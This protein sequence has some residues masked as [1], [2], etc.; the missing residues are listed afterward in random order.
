[1]EKQYFYN[2]IDSFKKKML[3]AKNENSWL[4]VV[5]KIGISTLFFL[6]FIS[7]LFTNTFPS[8]YA[9]TL[10]HLDP[11]QVPINIFP[12]EVI[13]EGWN[14]L[15]AVT[16]QDLKEYSLFQ[17]FNEINSVFINSKSIK[18]DVFTED[19]VVNGIPNFLN[20]EQK[21][22]SDVV[23]G[24]FIASTT[25]QDSE[26]FE[27]IEG[28]SV[29]QTD[30]LNKNSGE[31]LDID[32]VNIVY[33]VEPITEIK[34]ESDPVFESKP[35]FEIVPKSE[36]EQEIQSQS[37]H[38]IVDDQ[39]AA[40]GFPSNYLVFNKVAK[41]YR[42]AVAE[43]IEI[44]S[45]STDTI[46][47]LET[48]EQEELIKEQ[49]FDKSEF[50][51]DETESLFVENLEQKTTE[52]EDIIASST[53]LEEI[54][55]TDEE[56]SLPLDNT[57]NSESGDLIAGKKEVLNQVPN[58]IS[59][60][61]FD[62]PNLVSG[63][64][65][66]NLQLRLSLAGQYDLI[67]GE[68]IPS[69]EVSY[70]FDTFSKESG[71]IIIDGEISNAI[72]GGYYLIS[73]PSISDP[74]L[75]S[76][77]TI[78]ISFI[79]DIE[80]LN[81][82]YVDSAWLEMNTVIYDK[83]LLALRSN[84]DEM[85]KHLKSPMIMKFM[86]DEIDFT[87]T[88]LPR[89]NL[90]YES[91]RNFLVQT[92]RSFIGKDLATIDKIS[93]KHN[94][95]QEI[96]V[97][98]KVSITSDGLISI[99]LDDEDKQ[100]LPPG[101]YTVEVSVD[102]GGVITT[103]TFEFQWG[104]LS[105]NT[106]QTE[107]GNGE[108]VKIS[109]A[110]LASNGSTICDARLNLYITDP[111]G[112]ISSVPVLRS[113]KCEGDNVV[114]V[115]DYSSLITT[116]EFG[117]YEIYLER[118]NNSG[119]VL[120]HVTETFYVVP[121]QDIVI[122][123]NGPTRIF[124]P[125][126]YRVDLSVHAL[127][128]SFD[129]KLVE[130]VPA[131]FV[132]SD[133]NAEIIKNNNYTELV[134]DM[135]MLNGVT[136][137]VSYEFNAPD[138]SPFLFNLGPAKLITTEEIEIVTEVATE[139]NNIQSISTEISIP[140]STE[141]VHVP[142]TVGA[143][144]FVTS[145][146][147][148]EIVLFEEHRQWQIASDALQPNIPSLSETPS[149]DNLLSTT[150][151]PTIGGFATI[152]PD[153]DVVE[154]EFQID[155]NYDFSSPATTTYSFNFP[156]DAGW[157]AATFASGA[158]T[159]YTIQPADA[160]TDGV[161]YW[162]RVR[163]KDPTDTDT[164]TSYSQ[165]R[166]ITIDTSLSRKEWHQTLGY[167]FERDSLVSIA[168]T[169]GAAGLATGLGPVPTIESFT[170]NTALTTGASITLTKPSGVEV[171][172]LLLI[173]VGNDDNTATAQWDNATLKPSGFTLINEAGNATA[174]A[175]TAAFYRIADGTEG[176]TINVPS[177]ANADYWGYYV[178][179]SGVDQV[180]P[181]NVTG[182]DYM[183]GNNTNHSVTSVTTVTDNSLAFYLLAG[184]GGDTFPF[185]VS[186]TGWSESSEIQAGT[187]FGNAA[188][189]WGTRDMTT[190]GATGNATVGMSVS[191]GASGFQFAL[192]PA[193]I[194]S[195]T[196]M[197]SEVDFDWVSNED[198]WGDISWNVTEPAGTDTF[199]SVYYS[200]A[201]TCD[202]LVSDVDLPGNS[203]GFDATS[204]GMVISSLSTSTYNRICLEMTLD[205]GTGTTSPTLNDWSINWDLPNQV[206]NIPEYDVPPAFDNLL[207]TSTP[208][209]GGFVSTDFESDNMEY[210]FILD[211]D[212]DF[213]SPLLTKQSS[214]YPTDAGWS[215]ATFAS[216]ATTT[217]TIQPADALTDG[218]TY[219]WKV[220]ARDPSGSNEWS[221]Y[222][223]ARS[224]TIDISVL[225]LA[226]HQTL[227][228][229]F[230]DGVFDN[231]ATTTG[232][233]WLASTSSASSVP[234][235]ESFTS[236]T[237]LT[238]GASI[239]LTK[240]SGVEVG[241]LLLIMVGND[242]NT[243]T[244]QWDNATLKPS[245]FT[246]INEAGNATADA[247]T[248]AFYRIADGTEGATINVPSQANA[249]YWGYYVRV[250]GVDQV[251]PINVTGADYMSGNNTN[252]SVTSVTTV[253][254]NSLAFYLLAGDGGDTFPFTV[255][256]TG[257]SESSEIQAGTGFGNAAGAWG[258]R[259]MTTAGATGNATV[260]MSVSDGASG[261][262]FALTP[263][264]I[265]SGTIMSSE[266]DFDWVSNEDD[267]GDIS[268]NVTEP[269]GTD[270]FL[271]VYYSN[272][273]TCDTLVSDVDLPGNSVGFDATST[274]MVISSLST[275]TYNRI[276]LEMTLD[277][278][279]GTTS[280]TLN[281]WSI[282]WDLPNQVPNIP[283][284]DVPPA[285]DNLLATSTPILG[286]FVSTD[287]ESDNMEYE[288]I[289][290]NDFDF[291]S[292]LL[293]KQSSNYPTDA[294]WSAA[295]F[296]SGAT[297]TY[298]IQ[299]ADALTDGVT[300]WWKVRARDPSGSNEWSDY[301]EARSVTIDISV[302]ELA[303]HQTLGYQFEDGVF[304]N[305]ATTTGGVWLASTSS[306]SSVPTI[307]SFTSN[308]ALT[309]GASITLTKPSG[310]EV[311]DLLL[312]MVG[313]DDNTA[314]A[315]WDNATLKPSG[316]TLINEAGNATADAHTAA[317]Y[318]IAD[319]TE[320]ATIN[321]PSQANADYWGYYVRVSGVDQVTPINVTGA[322]YM[323]GNNTNHSVTSVTTVTD[324]SLAFYLLAGD[325]GDTFPF[326]V[327]GTGWS[328]SSEIQAGTGF[329][330]A[331]G[332]WGTRDM[333]TAGAT[334]NATVGMSVSDGAS[335]FQ[336]ALTPASG[337]VGSVISPEVDFDWVS[338]QTNWG[339]IEWNITEPVGS[340]TLLQVYYSSSTVC[341]TLIPDGDLSGNAVGFGID[342]NN[343]FINSLS[344]ST[345][346]RICLSVSFDLGV[347]ASSPILDD[348]TIRWVIPNQAPNTPTL[349]ETP[350]FD[351][352]RA[353]TT[354]P[355]LGGFVST[356]FESDNMEYEFILDNDF[357]FGSPLLTK[358]SSNYPT[359]AG[360]SA[361]TFAS[362]A[363]TT[364]T[365]QPADAL[366][367]GVTYWWKVRARDPSGSNEWSDYSEARSVTISTAITIPE[368]FQTT[369]D[370]FASNF[371]L[372]NAT[373]SDGLSIDA[374]PVLVAELDG[375]STGNTKT[376]SDGS[377][378]A[379]IVTII[380]ED[381][382][383]NTNVD[384]VTYGGQTLT[385]ID[386]QQIGTGFSNGAWVGYL[387]EAGIQAAVGTTITPSW[388]GGAPGNGLQYMSAVYENVNQDNPVRDYSGNAL[389]SG[390]TITPTASI[391]VFSGDMMIY[392]TETEDSLTHTAATG[393]TEGVEQDTGGNGFVNA[394][395]YKA[396]TSDGSEYPEANWSASGNRLLMIAFALQPSPETGSVMSSEVDFDWV[397]N[398]TDWGEVI[399]HVN[400]P[401]G[402]EVLLRVYYSNSA[403]CDTLVPDGIL[404]G[405]SEGIVSGGS[406]LDISNLSTSTYNR[407]CLNATL[408]KGIASVSPVLE[409]WAVSWEKS[410]I[411]EQNGFW[412]Y[413]NTN[414]VTPTDTW[415][416]GATTGELLQNEVINS[417]YPTKTGDVLRLRMGVGVT[418]VNSSGSSFKLQYAAG[419]ICSES[420]E[421]SDVAPI[422]S[423][424]ALWRGYNNVSVS[425]GDTLPSASL[426]ATDKFETYEEENDTSAIPNAINT[427]EYGEWDWVI[428]NQA[429]SGTSYCFRM[430]TPDGN[431]FKTYTNYPRLVTNQSPTVVSYPVPFDNEKMASTSP[432][433]EFT[434]VDPEGENIDYQIQIDDD[435]DFSSPVADHNSVSNSIYF[436]NQ[437]TIS[438]KSPFNDS[439]E[440]RYVIPSTLSNDVTYWWRV[441]AIDSEAS[442]NYGDWTT[443]KSFTIDTGVTI[444]T[445]FQTT[446]EQFDTDTL[447]QTDATISDDVQLASGQSFGTTTS[448][449]IDF[450]WVTIGNA[451][452]EFSFTETGSANDILYHIEYN[453]GSSWQLIPD[454]DLAGNAS[455]YDTSPVDLIDLD[456]ETYNQIRI[457][458][459]FEN[460]SPSI[461]DWTVNWG[462]RVS[463][464]THQL[465][466]DNEKT[467]T[468]SPTFTFYTTD[469]EGDDLEYEFSW[470]TDV[471]FASGSTTVNSS[472]SPGFVNIDNGADTS[473]YFTGNTIS[474]TMQ[475]SLTD[476]VT[477]WWRTRAKDPTGGN[478]YSFWSEPWSFTV[479]TTATT[480]TW[481][482]TTKEQFETDTLASTIAS[483][484]DSI[485]T[486]PSSV[487]TYNFNGV[488]SPS[489]THVG[490]DFEVDVLDPT[491]PPTVDAIDTLTVLGTSA[492][493]PNLRSGIAGYASDAEATNGQYTSLSSS[494]DN[495]W[496]I[497][498]PN[499]GDNAVF[500]AEFDIA[501][502]PTNIDQI[503]I[504]LEGFQGAATD[505]AW[506]G[507]WRPGTTTPYW[508]ELDR[509]QQTVTDGTYTGTITTNISEYFDGN[510][511]IHVI[512][513]NEDDNDSLF[514]DYVEVIITSNSASSGSVIGTPLD[515]DNGSGP[516]W[517]SMFWSDS[518][519]GSSSLYYQVEY[520]NGIGEWEL[521]PDLDLS[522]NSAG[523]T[524]SPID[525]KLLNTT[526]YNEIR[527]VANFT[528]VAA[529]CPTLN[530]WTIEWSRGFT[531]SGTAYEYDGV[532][533][534][535]TGTVA[536][537][538][539]GVL[540]TGKT[541]SISAGSW[542][543]DNV[544]YFEDDIV[545]VFINGAT[546]AEEAVAVTAYDGV[547]DITGMRLQQRHLTI[548]SDD[549]VAITNANLHTYDFTND[550]DL[551]FDVDGSNVLS[552][553]ADV[554]CE[555]AGIVVLPNNTYNPG[556]NLT[557]HD[558][559][560]AGTL[561]SGVNT[562]RVSGSWVNSAT[563]TMTGSTVIFTATSTTETI[564]STGAVS[565][566][567]NNVTFGETAGTATWTL[568][569]LFDVN[570]VLTIDYGTLNRG[571]EEISVAGNIITNTNGYWSGI[572]TT[573]IDGTNPT[574]WTDNNAVNQNIGYV[575]VDGV[576]KVL[577]AG[578]NI[579]MQSLT[580]EAN[581]IFDLNNQTATINEGWNNLNTFTPRLGTIIFAATTTNHS[582]TVGGDSFYNLT[583]NGSG[584]SWAFTEPALVVSN[585]FT[586]ATGT[587]TMPTAT[588]TISG[589]FDSTGGTFA[590]NNGV[591]YF[592]SGS[593][594]TI[595]FDG[596]SFT[597]ASYDLTFNGAGNWTVNDVNATSSNDVT[598][599]AGT[600]NFPTGVFSIGGTLVDTGG[601]YNGGSGT[602]LFYSSASE[603]LTAGGSAFS[604]LEFDG[605]GNWSF[606]DTNVTVFGDLVVTQGALTL[607]NGTFNL[608][609]SYTNNST[610]NPGTGTLK[611]NS[612]DI[613]EI[614]NFG[615]SSLYDVVFDNVTGGWT[616]S[617]PATTTND[618]TLTDASDWTLASG[619]VLSV[620]GVFTN[621]VGGASTTWTGTTL[622]L[623]NGNYSINTK[624]DLGDNYETLSIATSTHVRMWN[625]LANSHVVDSG[626]SLYSQDHNSVDGDLYI[627]GNYI[628][629]NGV[630]Y[631]SYAT[632]FDGADLSGSERQSN[633]RFA[634]GAKATFVNS[635]VDI[636]GTTSASTTI[637]N[638]GAGT[639]TVDFSGGTTTV[640]YY[641]F[642]DLGST[643]VSFLD[644]VIVPV[645]R[646]GS[647]TVSTPGGSAITLSSTTIDINP[648]KQVY[649]VTFATTTPMSG[650]NISQTDGTPTSYWWFREGSGNLNGEANDNDTGDPGSVR[651][652][653]SSLT[654][655]VAGAVY[656]DDGIS[657]IIGGTCDGVTNSVR[658][659]VNGSTTY[660]GSC[661]NI[662]GTYSISGVVIVGDP[663]LTIYLNDASGG[664]KGSVITRTPTSDILDLDIY[665]NRVIVRNE[666]VDAVT[667]ANM[668]TY[669]S[670]DDI[671]LSFTASTGTTPVL[672][673]NQNTELYVW[674]NKT[675]VPGGA[676]T[677]SAN[678]QAN[679][680][681]G[682]LV[683][684]TSSTF[685]ANGTSTY[686]IGGRLVQGSG[687]S[688]V[689]A[690]STV[691]MNATTSGKSITANELV[692]FYDLTF[693]GIGGGWNIGA[694]IEVDNNMLISTGTV[695][696]T[697]DITILNG[698][699]TGDGTLSLGGGTTTMSVSNNLG[700]NTAWTFYNLTLGN[701]LVVG[702]T[703][704]LFTA[705]TTVSGTLTIA[706]A[707]FLDAG[708]TIWDLAGTGT[709]FT[710][711]GT[712]IY[713]TSTVRYS[714]AGADVTSLNYYN[715]DIN[716]G[717]GS[718]TYTSTGLG[719]S[720]N[721]SLT[722]GGEASTTFDLNT[723]DVAVAVSGD[724]VIQNNGSFIASDSA[725]LSVAGDWL[726][727]GS[728]THNSGTVTFDTPT[729]TNINAGLSAFGSVDINGVGSFT[730]LSHAT[731]TNAWSLS[732]HSSFTLSGGQT[733][734]VGGI[735]SNNLAGGATTWSSSTLALYGGG[736]YEI[737][738]STTNDTYGT[739][740]VRDTTQIRMWNSDASSYDVNSTASLYSQDHGNVD[741]TLNIYGT[742][743]N[744]ILVD[745]WSYT[746]D[747]DGTDLTGGN[748]RP[749][750]VQFA[751][752]SGVVL[753]AG[754]TL[755][756]IG[757]P[758]AST[759]ITNQGS[760]TYGIS[761][762]GGSTNWSYYELRNLNATGLSF[763]GTPTVTTLS[764]GDIELAVTGGTGISV[765]D[766]V[767]DNNPAKTFTGN[768]FAL[769]AAATGFNVTA[770]G[771][772]VSSWRF[773]NHFGGYDGESFD[774]DPDG[775][776]GYI[777]WDD[778]AALI[779][780]SGKVYS[781][782]GS[783]ISTICDGSTTNISLEVAGLTNYLASCD[784]GTGS[785]S[786]TN[787]AYSP[788]DS[789]V[790]YID[791][792]SAKAATVSSAPIS[793]IGNFNLYEN[794]VIVRHEG[795]DPL[796]IDDMSVWDSSDD[797]DI[798]FTAISS[799]P[800][801]LDLPANYKLIV[802]TG[803]TF[804]P[805][806]DVTIA[807]GGAGQ[808]YD[809]TLELYANSVFDS[810]TG[811]TH[812]IGGS[813][814]AS[815]TAT[816]NAGTSNIILT[817]T[818]S[819][820][821]VLVNEN[822]FFNLTFNGSGSWYI[823]DP[824]IYV[825]NDVT[826]TSG[827]VTM[828]IATSTFAGSFENNGG[829]FVASAVSL[830]TSTSSGKNIRFGGSSFTK[831]QFTGFG[832]WT[833]ID[834]DATSTGSIIKTD[835]ALTLPSGQ[836]A[837]G[838]DFLNESGSIDHNNGELVLF[839]TSSNMLQ[840]TGSDLYA[841][842]FAGNGNYTILDT[843][844]TLIE[845]LTISTGT[846]TFASGTL[847]IGGSFDASG[848]LFNNS[849]GTVLL[850]STTTGR[851]IDPGTSAFYDLQIG[852][853]AGGYTLIASAT[854]TNN[855]TIASVGNFVTQSS[856]TIYVG[857]VFTNSVGGGA[858]DWVGSTLY[859]DGQSAYTINT[860][861][862]GGD[863][864][865]VLN[866]GVNSD[867]R[868]WNSAA[869]TTQI[870][871]N[872]SLYS[873]D[874]NVV[875]GDLYIYGDFTIATTTEYWN[876]ATDFD[877][878]DISGF[879]R[880]VNVHQATNSTTTLQS[881]TLNVVGVNGN[882]TNITNQGSGTYAFDLTGGTFN[883]LY[884]AFSNLDVNGLNISGTPTLTSLSNGDFELA[885][886][887]GTL[888]KVTD[889][890]LNANA[891]K[892]VTGNSFS[893]TTAIAG[894]NVTLVGSTT[895]V[896]TFVSHT[897]N[898]D[899]EDF[900][901]DDG[902]E[903]GSIRWS[904]S[905]CLLTQ[906]TNFR[907]RSDD[908]G[909]QVPDNEWFDVNWNARKQ[910]RIK[911]V[912][913]AT[914]TDAAIQIFVAYDTDMQADFDDLRFTDSTGISEIPYWLGSTTN[915]VAA[916]VWV[917]VPSLTANET[918]SV[919]M[920]YNNP[921]ATSTSSSTQVFIATDDFEDNNISEYSGQTSLFGT[922]TSYNYD[923]TY[924]LD[925]LGNES[926]R[927]NLGGIYRFDQTVSQGETFRYLQ[928]IDTSAGSG[929]EVCTMFGVQSPGSTNQN[930][931]VC[932][933]Q[934]GID[935]VS[936]VKDV[937]DNDSSGTILASSTITYSTGWYEVEIDWGTDNNIFVSLYDSAN[938]LVATT[939]VTDSTY[940]SGG[941]GFT[942]W[943]HNGGWDSISSRP[944]LTNE[945]TIYFGVEQVDGGAT[946]EA[947]QNSPTSFNVSDV[948]R[949]RI[950]ID[951][952]G[953]PITNQQF[954]LEYAPLG[955]A[956]SCEAVA[957]I[958]YSSV[959]SQ[960]SCGTSPVCMQSSTHITNGE[961]TVDL[962][963]NVSGIFVP[964][965]VREDPTN[966]T[967]NLDVDQNEY[968][969]L[970]YVIIPTN[971][972]VDENL[973]FRVTNNG[974]DLDTYLSV[975]ELQLKFDPTFG[976]V[977]LNS[978]LDISLTSGTT[979]LVYATGT[980]TDLNGYSD[981]TNA[982]AT[983]YRSGA[984]ASCT[985]NNNNCYI[986][987]TENNTCSFTDCSG[988]S[989]TLSCV[990]DMQFHADPTDADTY[991]GEEWLAYLEAEDSVG[992]YDFASAPGVELLTLRALAVDSSIDYG[993]LTPNSDTGSFNPT[994]TVT[995]LGNAPIDV[996]V[997][998]SDMTGG[999]SSTIPA[1000]QQKVATS[1001][1002]T[1003]SA[1004]PTCQQLSST[1005]PVTLD[1006]NMSKP[1007]TT[1008]P[1009][1010]ESD[1011]YWGINVPFTTGNSAHSGVNLFTAIGI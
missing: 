598:I 641:D 392:V 411:Y 1011:V 563:S 206:P 313:N 299:P 216:G 67:D 344:T 203:V 280:P 281:D 176:A 524:T 1002:F 559:T 825:N 329:G 691:I 237:A 148:N 768:R 658:L 971:N 181:I 48:I 233:V 674:Q 53:N 683:L 191:D 880:Q 965:E 910:V 223:E 976:A 577:L 75:L 871:T 440:I 986:L 837:V 45:T 696:G 933:E 184:D 731:A 429:D 710:G 437:D 978:G 720:V 301:S 262:Q 879:E 81:A 328:E 890:A 57:S 478:S 187:G 557:T 78:K 866:I 214:N 897:G 807:G 915:A 25:V 373:T 93:F 870:D 839:S 430:V 89:F 687:A 165:T 220:R 540:Q 755:N 655:T 1007:A 972:V 124:P 22:F 161:T 1000:D 394:S 878:T 121:N 600:L 545:T 943:F 772:S 260:G 182:A 462:L 863:N 555:D 513:F 622:S 227:G 474:Y 707:H 770:T 332:A 1009:P 566:A 862:V 171:G 803:K 307:E 629:T 318:R 231:A 94:N 384:T 408:S 830:F 37:E 335:G 19:N 445:W 459:N 235:I 961:S 250:S 357:D 393:Y 637:A 509:F 142:E 232:G 144:E 659:V 194:T 975:A 534:L 777:V 747:F 701:G 548:G 100:K 436:E 449:M 267:W 122:E 814:V 902:T 757:N 316:F 888:I 692:N 447:E 789:F 719:I 749:V 675:F 775:D 104:L 212:F 38:E 225:E 219:W 74:A 579:T 151:T 824:N 771:T 476:G 919:F 788:G 592:N 729:A 809:G 14:N 689:P 908:G 485:S 833:I 149:F 911:N 857:G 797:P 686:I 105:V 705:T 138:L 200:N 703:T 591:M 572:G 244:A 479:D 245:G 338:G 840:A 754:G 654:I 446:E 918:T 66:D 365:I 612:N 635:I 410:P 27:V 266:V 343:L 652:D 427:G 399:W 222:S 168:T 763:S 302:L 949:L 133:T 667:I 544:T 967:S 414:A 502:D 346:N 274:G 872:A 964:G 134:W 522:G 856:P 553:C 817:T 657:P 228:Y 713:D 125:A 526:T 49:V 877:G 303:W 489:A 325:G 320:G 517:G 587:V 678:S 743:S 240:P 597:N 736:N 213:G 277:L 495:R 291:G 308:T 607:P 765:T 221:D 999:L 114:D 110:A 795:V 424:T 102:E 698:S 55:I 15:N 748:E 367:D 11:D 806:G 779:T 1004:C 909:A 662:D 465:L 966:I 252:H 173:M 326:T 588:T 70:S 152:D 129:G 293:T 551:F 928:Y 496:T 618:F 63:Q 271:S 261:F 881:G 730:V 254:D 150:T 802:W 649:N 959:P 132:I 112:F 107:Y 503:D 604:N 323:S 584:G 248:A 536:V 636:I 850:N 648:A 983:I 780:I 712:F 444:S 647:Y 208:I 487:V 273:T 583:F 602:V 875:D 932:L 309:T 711:S 304:D 876:Y 178:R 334:G 88:E 615:S 799:S 571:I 423:S 921:T 355:S 317:F 970:E 575:V 973:C 804:T 333:T 253:T 1010:V 354:L 838:A 377:D 50:I 145:T 740:E 852:A 416:P 366:T 85:L 433:F 989:C 997:T 448:S 769:G 310:V 330:N 135:T 413:N 488:T 859:L 750:T 759:T 660:D 564:D 567:F 620:G 80:R 167:Q 477:Y 725:L 554:S 128:R 535:T 279:T 257:W 84:L 846:V 960:A 197:S 861:A 17:E 593:A 501:E 528:C 913:P 434:G 884:Y 47:K 59:L 914:Y 389:T 82:L 936:L 311:G 734:A 518:E 643:G 20:D 175:H 251:T 123:R 390:T 929:D 663:T 230:E 294:G 818:G 169:T 388:I 456:T 580:I 345:Y 776:P 613:G 836:F 606:S 403:T 805:E 61:G 154:Y 249:D 77:L 420:L 42:F 954:L 83:N 258:T 581:D 979:T 835:G 542:T 578:S 724:V 350:A 315:Q 900:D 340:D 632:D 717:S 190:A 670:D 451:W 141:S 695:T 7:F 896:W 738:A 292:P 139:N 673:T 117:E 537:A 800:D 72:N 619:Q 638:Q 885:V 452:G 506:L 375:W 951:N 46:E 113:G 379:L 492:S 137:T 65:I 396:I 172:D 490:R 792:E 625:S 767:I 816:F 627:F 821:S 39:S 268:W 532:T 56:I 295:T 347:A 507:I 475:S 32:S 998:G 685:V 639:Y 361:A 722:I 259:D 714:G 86:S 664:E 288:F 751:S 473:P 582:I 193:S 726:N 127:D 381:S 371:A 996:D 196:I 851:I 504:T 40:I 656:Q 801:T 331:A 470:S 342:Q 977:N 556:A 516:A 1008:T 146:Q 560:N 209:L 893:T 761:V 844:L 101:V 994:T 119:D 931:A 732:N 282:N 296:A 716:A 737:N 283:E 269:A 623:E 486:I 170:S 314:T 616:I 499:A 671:D 69:I 482:Q 341:D 263:A 741:G 468:T 406:P 510:N 215:A 721:N 523:F 1001:T 898:L 358:Q 109:M 791:G 400:E 450:D 481:F 428:E 694:N 868:M 264:S 463:V 708:S 634:N 12:S 815:S 425:D 645:L 409:D 33:P 287:F 845:S 130:R 745:E 828:P 415:P 71:S 512:F 108:Q 718:Q 644:S 378:R 8:V 91:Q 491:D 242:D 319:G 790:V 321:V 945:P 2:T 422:G 530:D 336:F 995:N 305:A 195:G 438:D 464:P 211:N 515:F 808:P 762:T 306:A 935:R 826:I 327:S 31:T 864:Y 988:N 681:D 418:S 298:T 270:T 179:V 300:Y 848:G 682:S 351:N 778:S 297:T 527:P 520:L 847:S 538:V 136:K 185:T 831:M 337:V 153:G 180:T 680:Y 665:A 569:S 853:P 407:I 827:V 925:N 834:T 52:I 467:G 483:T 60:S 3:D 243:A 106:N 916:E 923:G 272:A 417:T 324:N 239:T 927:A 1:M 642:T 457:R 955:V 514:V 238:T 189:A 29:L 573:T 368:W 286:G 938:T 1006:L 626:G 934:F 159:T 96:G 832:D 484:T 752:G 766:S 198:D 547:P 521:I 472:S 155:D 498:D 10:K 241:D 247:H 621:N 819:N 21:P 199:L 889:Q 940:T 576:S 764:N 188:G 753:S 229:Q 265:T 596:G 98:P 412:W 727:Y 912:D 511:K 873:Q 813:F 147:I 952:T 903:C 166:S 650:Y 360:W 860:K 679:S 895:N 858:T 688:F 969:E 633:V 715:L 586:I 246:L 529:D 116:G 284:Y 822:P 661:S 892:V 163:A 867:I 874:H 9:G 41:L 980:V 539:N 103:D 276:C 28:E 541:A 508:Q 275:S 950:S 550:E 599:T 948:A 676:I 131:D 111:K 207:A 202:T 631:W 157:S 907:W 162:W 453:N 605:I 23:P 937:V 226:W 666:D 51:N 552:M 570:G 519:P 640:Q 611:F 99:S 709:V 421:W 391:D 865:N 992:G 920:Y 500:W 140:S 733:L 930:Y 186:G 497:T 364:Y 595:T 758:I 585:D 963:T 36:L 985:A 624:S 773:T 608:G 461:Q 382:G 256:G 785:Y 285:F 24:A 690:S 744:S 574:T 811:N 312:I 646:N 290:D 630:D 183:S 458:A 823:I 883:A 6:T 164:W 706:N 64:F 922:G 917:K 672:V 405:N 44:I 829:S 956:P 469:P 385:E 693:S 426:S 742:Y 192:T 435:V 968:V 443:A 395:A 899:G 505:V 201:T 784:S 697:G 941:Y 993:S 842:T 739:L 796:T 942:Y 97:S 669:D 322:D 118:V 454:A 610:V 126:S 204:T 210:E 946:W 374:S 904:N 728:F 653:D 702:T 820:R 278:G 236:N 886:N 460:G 18:T 533:A 991:E 480:S 546:D 26:L 849:T 387:D 34:S 787:V 700:G 590:H 651:F 990:A 924:G 812:T 289:L 439:E 224:V 441:R 68:N 348:W 601:V 603:I 782:E 617:T 356:D 887:G 43:V 349:S 794:R 359:D 562:L 398:Q 944:T 5:Q 87:R 466:F 205:L 568:G 531:V 58:Y 442:A 957:S 684:A 677:L 982:T 370:Q 177:Q 376:I 352:Y 783:T 372:I 939:S 668:A 431:R 16:S 156:T 704:P 158:T 120:S 62:V 35:E 589:S 369:D 543:I 594:E 549:N 255:S 894:A 565:P 561:V 609:G 115:P 386:D 73:L 1003:Y 380:S 841:V 339:L 798:P 217:Y 786:I 869:T 558:F 471:T 402:T 958:G 160:L 363:T 974:V 455:G 891:S 987:S 735:F 854:T 494:D 4:F 76:D 30:V 432:W 401:T 882:K 397:P 905:S 962:L 174:D 947:A 383:T 901:V 756:V 54:S 79:G 981:L 353:T 906:Q 699:L 404:A 1005:T 525:L 781:D 362:G 419:D 843:N 614:L 92:F 774:N 95:F 143:T 628:N 926:G 760:G 13:S 984:G 218:V 723:N 746:I 493:T 234:T 810:G 793:S 953:L 90:R 855:F